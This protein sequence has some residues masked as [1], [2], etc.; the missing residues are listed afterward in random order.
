MPTFPTLVGRL[1]ERLG[2]YPARVFHVAEPA[3]GFLD[4][5]FHVEAPSGGWKPGHE[6]QIMATTTEARRY[7]AY[8]V[9]E[10]DR[11]RV[12]VA[13]DANGPG[14]AW[15]H[16]LRSGRVVTLVAAKHRP[17]RVHGDRPLLLGDGSS[18]GTF[19]AYAEASRAPRV[20]LE[21]PPE[22]VA[23]LREH[24]PTYELL[25]AD[26]TPGTAT[27]RWL[28]EAL[29]QDDLA[30]IDGALLL[31]HA[32][33]IQLQRRALIANGILDRRSVT[34]KPYWATGKKGL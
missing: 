10:P 11:I 24:W 33:S 2:G 28:D 1:A 27:Q 18:L 21:V 14:T 3:P 30:G 12:L 29:V 22:S 25:P 26:T 5:E 19:E 16:Q 34:T 15:M 13:L 32:G 23:P 20:V 8:R 17:L 4:I 6:L 9:L 31:G 7:T